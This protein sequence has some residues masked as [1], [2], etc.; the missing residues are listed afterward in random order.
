MP[1]LLLYA[2]VHGSDSKMV[3][4]YPEE[5][6]SVAVFRVIP[7]PLALVEVDMAL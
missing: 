1:T 5:E 3:P 2:K 6:R 7:H 4:S